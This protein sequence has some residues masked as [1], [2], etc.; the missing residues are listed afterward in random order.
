MI[1]LECTT[2]GHNKFYEFH[3]MRA[4]GRFTVKGLFGAIGHAPQE[5]IIYDGDN[6]EE[7]A[8]EMQRKLTEKRK[9]GYVDVGA[10]GVAAPLPTQKKRLTSRPS[11]R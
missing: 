9:K 3:F 6:E 7:A 5:A 4:T 1:R 8:R 10:T 2:G 11:G